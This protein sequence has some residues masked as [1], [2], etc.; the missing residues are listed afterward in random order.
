MAQFMTVMSHAPGTSRELV[1]GFLSPPYAYKNW[2]WMKKTKQR[3]KTCKWCYQVYLSNKEDL[4]KICRSKKFTF[5]LRQ[6]RSIKYDK[7]RGARY[8]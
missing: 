3:L 8:E 4:H 5:L 2:G 1:W 7:T 6:E